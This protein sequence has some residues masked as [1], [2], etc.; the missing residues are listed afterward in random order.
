[1]KGVS[2]QKVMEEMKKQLWLAGPLFT[3]GVLQYSMQVISV[4]FI[5]HLG[6]VPLSAA[7]L[8]TS[9]ASVIGYNLLVRKSLYIY[10]YTRR[11]LT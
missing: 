5:G 8:A 6:E 3:V 4:M 9:F 7:S 1:M 11:V 2:R 10:T